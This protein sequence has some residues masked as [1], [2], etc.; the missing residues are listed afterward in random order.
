[1][2]DRKLVVADAVRTP[3]GLRGNALAVENGRVAWIGSHADID[4]G[5]MLVEEFPGATIVPGL[6]DAH[7]HPVAYTAAITG[8]S[9]KTAVNL[10]DLAARLRGAAAASP[11]EPVVAIRLDDEHL[12]ERC[13]PTR[14]D[15]DDA[16]ADRPVLI[17][18]YCGHIAVANTAALDAAGIS[19]STPDPAGGVIDRDAAGTPTGVLRETAIDPVSARLAA[20]VRIRPAGLN[21]AMRGLAGLGLTSIGAMTRTGDGPWATLGNEAE[22]LVGASADLPIRTHSYLIAGTSEELRAY[23]AE[24]DSGNRGLLRW[25]GLKR[26]GDGSLGG[27][28]AAMHEPFTDQPGESGTLRITD[29]DEAL[30][31]TCLAMGGTVAIH[32]IGDLANTAVIDIF[33][34]FVGEGAAGERLRL[35]H[36]SVLTLTDIDRLARLGVIVSVQPAFMASETEWL[37]KRVGGDRMART[38]PLASLE[39]AGVALAGGS[40]CPVEPPDPWAGMALARD[41]AGIVPAEGLSAESAF[42]LFTSG[43]AAALGEAEPLVVGSPA[44][45]LVID[46]DPVIA[47][48]DEVRAV[49]VIRTAISGRPVEVDRTKPTWSE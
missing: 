41:R 42:R 47:T 44:D 12:A 6:R 28:T 19:A 2:T 14:A 36:A 38:Y 8:T 15:L 13:L 30:A 21:A 3:R 31:R 25:A 1:V 23:A 17:H 32:A 20:A 24:I 22:I 16:V 26:F 29:L 9:L 40:D 7:F 5:S 45:Y 10:A 49:E 33:E 18:R 34:K 4:S 48:P 39:S 46:R 35:E 37:E 27:H 11:G 43:S